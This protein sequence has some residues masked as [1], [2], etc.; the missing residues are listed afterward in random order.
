MAPD[1]FGAFRGWC[2][3]APTC[4][5]YLP[6]GV[7]TD[8]SD[9]HS[10]RCSRCGFSPLK[11]HPVACV[12]SYDP[13]SEQEH[14][15]RS[16][17]DERLQS[18]SER[19]RRHK[20][21]GDAAFRAR[22]YRSA[23]RSYTSALEAEPDSAV[24]LSNRCQA[25]LRAHWPE[26]AL[27][28]AKRLVCVAP[29]WS[30]AHCRLGRCLQT[31]ERYAEE[32]DSFASA[33]RLEPESLDS[34]RAVASVSRQLAAQRE[35]TINFEDARASTTRRQAYDRKTVEEYEAKVAAKKAGKIKE[36]TEWS[37]ANSKAW[38]REFEKRWKPLPGVQLLE[39]PK[40]E[41]GG[42][43]EA[44]AKGPVGGGAAA[45]AAGEMSPKG[46]TEAA[47]EV[48]E[49]ASLKPCSDATNAKSAIIGSATIYSSESDESD[50]QE[51]AP[52]A[53]QFSVGGT[54]LM[55]PLR[56][57]LLVH[58][59]GRVHPKDDF[60]PMSYMM[61]Q[62]YYE[63]APDPV[64]VQ[65]RT[66]RWLQTTT[67]MTIIAYTV[68]ENL[69]RGD[70]LAVSFAPR[71]VHMSAVESG[72]VFLAGELE[73]LIDPRA[74]TW[75]TDGSSV[76]LTLVKQNR[77]MFDSSARGA[78]C[79]THWHRLFTSDQYTE[80]GMLG[81]DYSDLRKHIRH[82]NKM[83]DLAQQDKERKDKQRN[84]CTLCGKDNALLL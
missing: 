63:S 8:A 64:W 17:Y 13:H 6:A 51:V 80:R 78:D 2:R 7:P 5:E 12:E 28:D 23:Y 9:T 83:T 43:R 62:V 16:Q 19:T 48:A 4:L 18:L 68:P 46:A 27:S 24:L 54:T 76:Q 41:E 35:L 15:A 29:D 10:L 39:A 25:Y 32:V 42:E 73:H 52:P 20:S 57:F 58:E 53:S 77:Q 69:R 74:S 33:I 40:V 36:T 21:A 45:E 47:G 3:V 44:E 81:A 82:R 59:D 72:E 66:A 11:H 34:R 38:E 49:N 30:K 75:C 55:L 61:Q 70:A 14:A 31:L 1:A 71:Q 50:E 37:E 79:D 65:T 26:L 56:N 84:T 60:E 67:D 22:N